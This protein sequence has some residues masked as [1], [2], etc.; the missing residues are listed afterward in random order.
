MENSPL[1][2]LVMPVY[3][4]SKYLKQS[5]KSILDQTVRNFELIIIDDGSVD[6]SWDI[7]NEFKK[8]DK[9][10]IALKQ[11]NC[12]LVHTL[13]KAIGISK[14]KYLARLDADDVSHPKRFDKQLKWFQISSN[15]SESIFQLHLL[16]EIV[17][18]LSL[19]KLGYFLMLLQK[20]LHHWKSIQYL[21]D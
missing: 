4:S 16:L 20:R 9:R 10:I 17:L 15:F 2:S 13:N 19:K 1:I 12:G 6:N 7:I 11:S 3:N 8:K 5:I 18:A 14:G 21:H